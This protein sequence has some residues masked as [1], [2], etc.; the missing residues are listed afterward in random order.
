MRRNGRGHGGHGPL[1]FQPTLG[2]IK[3]FPF[4]LKRNFFFIQKRF[5]RKR[6]A[7]ICVEIHCRVRLIF[8]RDEIEVS[9]APSLSVTFLRPC[10]CLLFLGDVRML[11]LLPSLVACRR[12]LEAL[13]RPPIGA[14]DLTLPCAKPWRYLT[15]VPSHPS[16]VQ[17]GEF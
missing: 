1:T 14:N 12:I 11:P 16:C 3:I 13:Q 10:L 8:S 6:V 7:Q 5:T 9:L 2:I 4:F 15:D 17:P